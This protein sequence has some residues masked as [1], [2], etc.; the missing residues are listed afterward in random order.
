M[1]VRSRRVKEIHHRAHSQNQV[2]VGYWADAFRH[3]LL[4]GQIDALDQGLVEGNV[5][6]TVQQLA[7]RK[8]H[9][10]GRQFISRHLIEQRLKRVVVTLVDYRDFEVSII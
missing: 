3:E 5:L 7:D 8:P 1:L 10:R 6:S 2:V 9:F 4:P